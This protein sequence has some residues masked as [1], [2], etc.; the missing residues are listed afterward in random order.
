[1]GSFHL[2]IPARGTLTDSFSSMPT[3]VRTFLREGF[4]I[5]ARIPEDKLEDVIAIVLESIAHGSV[6]AER[7]V[8]SKFDLSKEDVRPLLTA[9]SLIASIV[10]RG[11]DTADSLTKELVKANALDAKSEPTVLRF[12]N[13]LVSRRP[14]I[15]SLMERSQL[16]SEVLPSLMSF[17]TTVDVRVGFEKGRVAQLLPVGLVHIETDAEGQ[18]LWMQL[19][20][21]QLQR[22]IDDLREIDDQMGAVE[23]WITSKGSSQT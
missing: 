19:T 6:V 20:R 14:S 3:G 7:Q 9:S 13:A 12:A 22:L 18:E 11:D 5:L 1:M 4:S 16:A 2:N 21:T 8:A 10:S 17:D 15:R 23:S